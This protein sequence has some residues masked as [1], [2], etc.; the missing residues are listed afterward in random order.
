MNSDESLAHAYSEE[1][2]WLAFLYVSE[3]LTPDEVVDFEERLL[4]DQSAREAVAEA[5]KMADGLWMAT[6][7][8]CLTPV[9]SRVKGADSAVG[10]GKGFLDS[11]LV[12][13]VAST[14]VAAGLAFCVG[15]WFSPRR[16]ADNSSPTIAH[17][18]VP[19]ILPGTSLG[20]P[21]PIEGA[22]QLVGIWSD[23][24]ALL[25]ELDSNLLM[26]HP[27]EVSEDFGVREAPESEDDEAFAWMLAAVS[28]A[29]QTAPQI[30]PGVMEN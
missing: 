5:M 21:H 20:L 4:T 15:W 19:R 10:T 14:M 2:P 9:A 3:E 23:S 1:L 8:D 18:P 16:V 27:S 25:A 22:E 11:R 6:A 30:N 17:Q 12:L 13:W 26:G 29:S 28:A 24:H 7:L